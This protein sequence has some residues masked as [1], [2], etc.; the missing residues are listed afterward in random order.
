M[1]QVTLLDGGMGLEDGVMPNNFLKALRN[2]V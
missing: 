1:S 2:T